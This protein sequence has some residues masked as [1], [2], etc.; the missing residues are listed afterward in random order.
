VDTARPS[1]SPAQLTLDASSDFRVVMEGMAT[2]GGFAVD[3][4]VFTTGPC[5]SKSEQESVLLISIVMVKRAQSFRSF[6]NVSTKN[7]AITI[8]VGPKC[9]RRQ[10]R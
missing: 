8:L 2:N 9:C 10:P 5:Q 3:D 1:W 6:C 4:I 7:N